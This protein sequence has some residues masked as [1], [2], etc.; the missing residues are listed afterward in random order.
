M[1]LGTSLNS[2]TSLGTSLNTPHATIPPDALAA[3]AGLR[4]AEEDVLRRGLQS[5]KQL[6]NLEVLYS[7]FLRPGG[8]DLG[9]TVA[10]RAYTLRERM[11]AGAP[12]KHKLK[13]EALISEENNFVLDN[14]LTFCAFQGRFTNSSPH[15]GAFEGS[16]E[17]RERRARSETL[18]AYQAALGRLSN[19][20][21]RHLRVGGSAGG[22][23]KESGSEPESTAR[24]AAEELLSAHGAPW[25]RAAA[26]LAH[27]PQSASSDD[28]AALEAMTK[29][30]FWA[31]AGDAQAER[32]SRRRASMPG[33]FASGGGNGEDAGDKQS[34]HHYTGRFTFLGTALD[35]VIVENKANNAAALLDAMA[36]AFEGCLVELYGVDSGRRADLR[37]NS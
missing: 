22:G 24:R 4:L 14:S 23:A 3:A 30:P 34:A 29:E 26:L 19:L 15:G 17:Q 37:D 11:P 20:E 1:S 35:A 2:P 16:A 31:L 18:R 8:A 21:I 12:K 27:L 7:D 9:A 5:M 25:E 28:R 6:V 13:L 32:S 36:P 10:K 33:A